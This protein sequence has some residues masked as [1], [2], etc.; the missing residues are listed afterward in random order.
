MMGNKLFFYGVIGIFILMLI[1]SFAWGSGTFSN[2]VVENSEVNSELEKYRSND[3]PEDCRLPVY[4][5]S[6]VSWKEHLSHH[7]QTLYCLEYFE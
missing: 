5:K 6:I 1:G 4:E 3:I 7:K 2:N